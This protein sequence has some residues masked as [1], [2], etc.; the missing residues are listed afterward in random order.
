M[1]RSENEGPV[2]KPV[3]LAAL[4]RKRLLAQAK[5]DEATEKAKALSA[6]RKAI[7]EQILTAV[8]AKQEHGLA[9]SERMKDGCLYSLGNRRPWGPV[10]KSRAAEVVA[11]LVRQGKTEFLGSPKYGEL[12]TEFQSPE[13]LPGKLKD[14]VVQNDAFYLSITKG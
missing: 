7:E 13:H 4:H 2:T 9:P 12:K 14:L 10:D 11:E 1:K 5:E 3:S 8:R 6:K